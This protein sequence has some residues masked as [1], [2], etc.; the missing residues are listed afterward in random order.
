MVLFVEKP[1]IFLSK[2]QILEKLWEIDGDVGDEHTLTTI[3]SR[4][5]KEIET[6]EHKYSKTAYG[7]CYQWIGGEQA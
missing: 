1:R 2:L 7:M 4:I 3:I 6:D 5:R